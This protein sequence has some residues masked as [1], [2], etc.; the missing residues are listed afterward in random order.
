MAHIDLLPTIV[1]LCGVPMPKT[2]PLDG[3]SLVPLLRGA[4]DDWP[5]RMIHTHRLARGIG[6][7]RTDRWRAVSNGKRWE[8]YDMV[9]DPGQKNDIAKQH[10]EVVDRLAAANIAMFKDVTKDG[11]ETIPIPIGYPERPMVE[12]PSHEA[13]LEP[14]TREGISY[15]GRSG[16]ANDYVTNWTDTDAYPWWAVDVVESGRYEVTLKYVCAEENLGATLRV[17]VAGQSVQGKIA[18]AHDPEPI[19]SPDRV[20]RGEVYEKVWAPLTLGTVDLPKGKTRLVVRALSKPGSEVVD[21]KAV[22]LR[23]VD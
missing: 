18:K 3:K 21:L 20:P 13:F 15:Y 12:M 9:A 23:R 2:L 6:S 8:L 5:E 11:F 19:P 14:P 4:A 17:T 16:W 22:Q 1:E 10:P 7:V